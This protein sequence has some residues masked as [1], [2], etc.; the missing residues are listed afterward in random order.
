MDKTCTRE[1]FLLFNKL[2]KIVPD[3]QSL[4]FYL[5]PMKEL[6]RENFDNTLKRINSFGLGQLHQKVEPAGKMRTFALV[7]S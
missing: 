5:L 7:D 1:L 3:V 2:A 6:F 4:S